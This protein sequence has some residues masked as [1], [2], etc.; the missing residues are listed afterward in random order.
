MRRPLLNGLRQI[1]SIKELV[2]FFSNVSISSFE[3]M[4]ASRGNVDW[5][6]VEQGLMKDMFDGR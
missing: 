1:E 6:A 5:D 4:Y 2:S 3:S